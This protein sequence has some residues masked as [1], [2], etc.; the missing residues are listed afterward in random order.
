MGSWGGW[1]SRRMEGI[2]YINITGVI[3]MGEFGL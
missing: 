1:G 3:G 2:G